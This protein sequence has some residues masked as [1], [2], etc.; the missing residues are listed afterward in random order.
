V[1]VFLNDEH[2]KDSPFH[3]LMENAN[4]G[5][6]W[7]EGP[8]LVGG[9]TGRHNPFKIHAVDADGNPVRVGGDPFV[10]GIS[11][12][13]STI[14]KITDNGDGTYDVDYV[15]ATPGN[16]NIDI[17]LHGQH[18]KDSP[19][20]ALIKPDVDPSKCYAEGPG[21][22][23][24]SDNETATFTI[25]ARDGDDVPKTEG[26]DPFQLE[27]NGPGPVQYD[28]K[29]NHDGTYTVH[30]TPDV[31]GDYKINITLEDQPIKNAPYS[32]HV[33]EGTD[34]HNTGFKGF[35]VTVQ[36]RDKH[37]QNK[38]IGGDL[39][40]V[41]AGGDANFLVNTADHGDGTYSASFN[42]PQRGS[43]NLRVF[44]NKKELAISPVSLRY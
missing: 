28:L 20:T 14:P 7:A 17:T 9:K 32:V 34:I 2:I 11:G 22:Q 16:Y 33:K 26:G 40:E 37:N 27:F 39:F 13:D 5:N 25:F 1:E 3:P 30:Y 44:F 10:V 35:V 19:F 36:T 21:L 29:D 6:S 41:Q 18:I 12:P 43:Y 38:K 31:A 8:G 4:A 23:G 15:V 42:P 24:A